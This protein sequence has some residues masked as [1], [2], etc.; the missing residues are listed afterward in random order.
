MESPRGFDRIGHSGRGLPDRHGAVLVEDD[1]PGGGNGPH[2]QALRRDA[3]F[4]DD[5]DGFVP[6][7]AHVQL[8]QILK[9]DG[10]CFGRECAETDVTDRAGKEL[11]THRVTIA[12]KS[13]NRMPDC[14]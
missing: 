9:G 4:L 6:G 14:A 13:W 11:K 1:V 7:D 12:S 2:H 3:E 5:A 8:G 10:G